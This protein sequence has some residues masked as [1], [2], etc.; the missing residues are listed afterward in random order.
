MPEMWVFNGGV[1]DSYVAVLAWLSLC[2]FPVL[3]VLRIFSRS[4]P[5]RIKVQEGTLKTILLLN[6]LWGVSLSVVWLISWF[7]NIF[8][9]L[10][11]EI[12]VLVLVVMTTDFGR[13][14]A[15]KKRLTYSW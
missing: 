13:Q 12:V 2:A 11:Q 5:E 7:D 3:M 1:L 15:G 6:V 14:R 8:H 10:S 9:T 4:T